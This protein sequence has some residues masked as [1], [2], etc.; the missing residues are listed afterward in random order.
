MLVFG[1][2]LVNVSGHADIAGVVEVVPLDGHATEQEAK[3]V[4]QHVIPSLECVDEV[5]GM[6]ITNIFDAKIINY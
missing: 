5:V 2:C 3:P 4:N 1:E 6:V